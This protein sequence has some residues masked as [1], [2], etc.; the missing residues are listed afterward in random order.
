MKVNAIAVGAVEFG[1]ALVFLGYELRTI[2][3]GGLSRQ[4]KLKLPKPARGAQREKDRDGGNLPKS[5]G[6]R[7]S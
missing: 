7:G 2:I 4:P 6:A 5:G 3:E 1:L